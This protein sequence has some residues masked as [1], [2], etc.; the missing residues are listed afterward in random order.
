M[1]LECRECERDL[2]GGHDKGCSMYAKPCCKRHDE[3]GGCPVHPAKA[4]VRRKWPKCEPEVRL[5]E[6]GRLDEVVVDGRDVKFV[7]LEYMDDDHVWLRIDL[8]RGRRAHVKRWVI[9]LRGKVRQET[10]PLRQSGA[11]VVNLWTG[12][13]SRK[14]Q[15]IQG[16]AEGD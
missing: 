9:P 5:T 11:I 15:R 1:S 13:D 7:H 6:E 14:G 12:R 10:E 3:D 16:R 2:R 4:G 8:K